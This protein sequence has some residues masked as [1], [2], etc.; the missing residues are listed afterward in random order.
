MKNPVICKNCSNENPLYTHICLNCKQ[1]LRDKVSNVDIWETIGNIIE[2]PSKAFQKIIYAEHKNFIVFLTLILAL[3]LLILSRFVSLPFSEFNKSVLPIIPLY[4]VNLVAFTI[5]ILLI[6]GGTSYILKRLD[7]KTRIRDLF[8]LSVFSQ[9]P[10][11]FAVIILFPIELIVFGNYLFSNNPYPFQVKSTVSYILIGFEIGMIVWS[12]V[13]NY[14][15]YLTL[16]ANKI[17]S[18]SITIISTLLIITLIILISFILF[19]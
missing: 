4:I 10:N 17:L 3:R 7:Y 8:S 6:A 2:S 14:I 9:L 16:T 5:L 18:L 1:F 12:I 13:L 11:I 19:I 15:S